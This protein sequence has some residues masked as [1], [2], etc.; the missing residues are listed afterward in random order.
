MSFAWATRLA[1]GLTPTCRTHRSGV[2]VKHTH[3]GSSCVRCASRDAGGP[4]D[5]GNGDGDE[6]HIKRY[7]LNA[8][9]V[10]G[11][12]TTTTRGHV[13]RTDLPKKMGGKDEHPQPVELL[14]SALIGCEQAT[15]AFVA[16]QMKPRMAL[17]GLTFEYVA[18]RDERGATSL[19]LNAPTPVPARLLSVTGT[20]T[21]QLVEGSQ[22]ES[23][24]RIDELRRA[25][26]ARCPV[27]NTLTAGGVRLDISWR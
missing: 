22:P 2:L 5:D 6:K 15:A 18:T 17:K 10:G 27:A 25:T 1:R 9:G 13:V 16:R 21:V 19:P 11:T 20:A 7:E 26:E 4:R 14:V 8:T 24:K 12:T 23:A 3:R